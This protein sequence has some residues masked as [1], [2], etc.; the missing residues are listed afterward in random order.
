[1]P[2]AGTRAARRQSTKSPTV[3]TESIFLRASLA[4]HRST[5]RKVGNAGLGWRRSR[6]IATTIATATDSSN[7]KENF[8]HHSCH[9]GVI[10]GFAA[11]RVSIANSRCMASVHEIL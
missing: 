6:V 1:M 3:A 2:R 8:A 5:A 11:L 9:A 10:A 4:N 7:D